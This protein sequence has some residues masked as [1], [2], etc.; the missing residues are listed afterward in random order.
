MIHCVL[1]L[2]SNCV[3]LL[4]DADQVVYSGFLELFLWKQLPC[5]AENDA[6]RAARVNQHSKVDVGQ[7]KSEL[8]LTI[9]LWK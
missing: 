1:Q 5:V 8:K 6:I 7:L 9:K 4:F 2:V 3:C